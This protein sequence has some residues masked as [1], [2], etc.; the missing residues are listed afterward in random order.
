MI[1]IYGSRFYGKVDS[2]EG[3]HQ[4]TRFISTQGVDVNPLGSDTADFSPNADAILTQI[5]GA[6]GYPKRILTGSQ[7]AAATGEPAERAA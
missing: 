5:A 1:V 3:Q 4:Q 6:T 2:Y 7:P